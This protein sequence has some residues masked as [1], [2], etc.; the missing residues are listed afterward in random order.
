[1]LGFASLAF[2]IEPAKSAFNIAPVRFNL[3]YAIAAEALTSALTITPDAIEVA[4]PLEVI[5]PVKLAFVVTV[6]ALPVTLPSTLATNVPF[7]PLKTSE[8]LVAPVS[9]VNLPAESS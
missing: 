7:V 3:L 5:S 6:S 8:E 2:A 1:M 4:L 9:I